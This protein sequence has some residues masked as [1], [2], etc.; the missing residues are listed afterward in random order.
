[1]IDILERTIELLSDIQFSNR[2]QE[3]ERQSLLDELEATLDELLS[4]L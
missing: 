2:E 3:L 1:M 4:E